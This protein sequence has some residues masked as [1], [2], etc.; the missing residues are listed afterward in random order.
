MNEPF[1]AAYSSIANAG[2]KGSLFPSWLNKQLQSAHTCRLDCYNFVWSAAV[3]CTCLNAC[4]LNN[5]GRK[6]RVRAREL[7]KTR[8]CSCLLGGREKVLELLPF[9]L[10]SWKRDNVKRQLCLKSGVHRQVTVTL[11]CFCLGVFIQS[12]NILLAS[13]R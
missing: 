11:S 5:L 9:L 10:L 2:T 1:R 13:M 4:M 3:F 8:P 12:N 6:V 7:Q